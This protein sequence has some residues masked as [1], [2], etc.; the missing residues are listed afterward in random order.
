MFRYTGAPN[1]TLLL[2]P[3]P[4]P[5]QARVGLVLWCGIG[6]VW[7]GIGVVWCG[8]GNPILA[9]GIAPINCSPSATV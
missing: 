8:I 4:F 2:Y 6:V 7:C 5:G 1:R 9:N 3:Y